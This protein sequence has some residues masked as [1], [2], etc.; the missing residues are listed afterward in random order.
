MKRQIHLACIAHIWQLKEK[1]S[2]QCPLDEVGSCGLLMKSLALLFFALAMAA[3][4]GAK[5]TQQL[6]PP[7]QVHEPHRT[8]AGPSEDI[9]L[10]PP[11]GMLNAQECETLFHHI[12]DLAFVQQQQSKPEEERATDADL[13]KAKENLHEELMGQCIGASREDFRYDCALAADTV[14]SLRACMAQ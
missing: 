13:A 8:D 12:F 14:S 11:K 3:C 9:P 7:S 6:P 10:A 1:I 2:G 4:G 5:S